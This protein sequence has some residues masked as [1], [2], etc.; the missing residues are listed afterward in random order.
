MEPKPHYAVLD[1]LRGVAAILV[2]V[3]HLSEVLVMGDPA[4]NVLPHG[5]LAVDFFFGLSG[6]VIGYAYDERWPKMSTGQFLLRRLIRLHP[7]VLLATV[8]GAVAYVF[9]PYPGPEHGVSALRMALTVA[10]ALMVLP[11]PALPER[12]DDTHSLDGPTWTLLQEYL[13]S[14]AY[15]LVLR[16]LAPRTLFWLAALGLGAVGLSL[17]AAAYLI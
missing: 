13:G 12:F 7:L 11:Y 1:G 5:A 8:I 3:F 15:A 16:H 10:A 17:F 2:V 14:L 6:F 4:R 9:S